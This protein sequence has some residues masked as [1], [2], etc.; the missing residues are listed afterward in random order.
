MDEAII[1]KLKT[2]GASS[3]KVFVVLISCDG[4][5]VDTIKKIRAAGHSVCLV[6]GPNVRCSWELLLFADAVLF[7]KDFTLLPTR[8]CSNSKKL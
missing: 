7:G 4:D 6:L 1:E 5:Y 2:L 8:V 3:S